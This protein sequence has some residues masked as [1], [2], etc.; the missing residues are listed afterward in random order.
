MSWFGLFERLR[1]HSGPGPQSWAL[2]GSQLRVTD[3]GLA[4]LYR[5]MIEAVGEHWRA[6]M[7][8]LAGHHLA[9]TAPAAPEQVHLDAR[10]T[11]RPQRILFG[12]DAACGIIAWHAPSAATQL[13]LPDS[14]ETTPVELPYAVQ[15]G[16]LSHALPIAHIPTLSLWADTADNAAT[17]LHALAP[18]FTAATRAVIRLPP[19]EA[20]VLL[21]QFETR[22]GRCAA[23]LPCTGAADPDGRGED[24]SDVLLCLENLSTQTASQAAA[25]TEAEPRRLTPDLW[26]V[27]DRA[28]RMERQGGVGVQLPLPERDVTTGWPPALIGDLPP[29]PLGPA[30]AAL[31]S[32]G[33]RATTGFDYV[34]EISSASLLVRAPAVLVLP[35]DGPAVLDPNGLPVSDDDVTPIA[36]IVSRAETA[37]AAAGWITDNVFAVTRS[38]PIRRLSSR[39][40]FLL[41][42]TDT[43]GC[44]Y[45]TAIWPR[46]EYLLQQSE[47]RGIPLDT[48]DVLAPGP[49]HR[50]LRDSVASLGIDT[51][52]VILD[53]E[54]VLYRQILVVPP[55]SHAFHPRRA[56]AFD[57]FWR[58]LA[59]LRQNARFVSFSIPRPPERLYLTTREG[60]T[61]LNGAALATLARSRGFQVIDTDASDFAALESLMAHARVIVGAAAAMGWVGLADRCALG[62]LIGEADRTPPYPVLHAAAACGH[63]VAM[64]CATAV[65]ARGLAMDTARFEALLDRVDSQAQI[66][67]GGVAR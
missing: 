59:S 22:P 39:P 18:W 1:L 41:G 34:A 8:D 42:T 2:P 54:D 53:V 24:P 31:Q 3:A 64:A 12:Q 50:L 9:R 10:L 63:S 35:Q 40:G 21:L 5:D 46:L 44:D 25:R 23:I 27:H 37:L 60:P 17:L 38:R 13:R 47:Q 51:A 30:L 48:F 6:D 65:G 29:A 67:S 28:W 36:D 56:A 66:T 52:N 49:A 57:R 11:G 16:L 15:L 26:N 45:L 62:V 14:T 58:R 4:A 33:L 20:R 32:G 61:L 43:T 7:F 55:A 19:E